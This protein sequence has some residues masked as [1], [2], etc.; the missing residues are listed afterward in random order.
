MSLLMV[1]A[2]QLTRHRT[3][4]PMLQVRI[5]PAELALTDLIPP[6][7]FYHLLRL[8]PVPSSA[9]ERL[10]RPIRLLGLI[11]QIKLHNRV[12]ILKHQ[13]PRSQAVS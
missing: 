8:V 1:E 5:L 3:I 6:A 7:L 10:A 13:F 12:T 11:L 9:R 2:R 4:P